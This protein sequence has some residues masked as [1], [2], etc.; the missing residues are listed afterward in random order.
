MINSLLDFRTLNVLFKTVLIHIACLSASS[1]FFFYF[2]PSS[3]VF[4]VFMLALLIFPCCSQQKSLA[5][6]SSVALDCITSILTFYVN[7]VSCDVLCTELI[8]KIFLHLCCET[9]ISSSSPVTRDPLSSTRNH[10]QTMSYRGGEHL[11]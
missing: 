6:L 5:I 4:T 2:F 10:F 11:I 9:V 3:G 7:N 1:Y 8:S